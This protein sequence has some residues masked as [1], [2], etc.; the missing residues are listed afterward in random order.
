VKRVTLLVLE[1][2][3]FEA[4]QSN[5]VGIELMHMLRKRQQNHAVEQA[6]TTAAQVF[7]LAAQFPDGDSGLPLQHLRSK[8]CDR[9]L[10]LPGSTTADEN[11]I[12]KA[13]GLSGVYRGVQ[14]IAIRCRLV[15]FYSFH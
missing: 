11:R 13:T 7:A 4:A 3:A 5:V 12:F 9:T 6:L 10:M 14:P 8:I 15:L 1:F 2:K